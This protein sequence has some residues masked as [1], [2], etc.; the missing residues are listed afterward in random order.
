MKAVVLLFALA[1]ANITYALQGELV[2]KDSKTIDLEE[3]GLFT[4]VIRFWPVGSSFDLKKLSLLEGKN[5]GENFNLV[6][7]FKIDYSAHNSEVVEVEALLGL[8]KAL[9][10]GST[11]KI[12]I[13]HSDVLLE[14][15]RLNTVAT[16]PPGE[17]YELIEQPYFE[18]LTSPVKATIYIS[19][20]L[21]VVIL[22]YIMRSIYRKNLK[23][24]ELNEIK[25]WVKGLSTREEYEKLGREIKAIEQKL[26]LDSAKVKKFNE[27][28]NIYQFRPDWNSNVDAEIKK[29]IQDLIN[30]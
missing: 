16:S 12:K 8:V 9:K 11:V 30:D 14:V 27:T 6:K 5:I 19:I 21:G 7:I 17:K 2:P 25:T 3:G 4:G 10:P 13:D 23:S 18:S 22:V 1:F 15:R 24:K 26:G 20:I 29:C 28:L